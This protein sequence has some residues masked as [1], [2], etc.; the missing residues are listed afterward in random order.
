[1]ANNRSIDYVSRDFDSIVDALISFAT[2][3]F[4]PDTVANRQWT[5]FNADDFSRTWLELVAYVGDLIF[6]YLDV[7]ATQSNIETATIRKNILD[8]AKQFGFVVSTASSSSEVATFML[9]TPGTVPIGFRVSSENGQEFFTSSSSPAPGSTTLEVILPV[10]QGAQRQESFIARG[11]QNEE[12]TLGVTGLV[13]DTTN[14]ISSLISPGVTVNGDT[15]ELVDTFI[16]SLPTDKHFRVLIDS[17]GRAILRFGD[18]VFGK[19]LS[20]ND[21]IVT[22]YRTGGGSAG[23]IPANT[24]TTLLDQSTFINAVTNESAFSGGADE[25]SITQL[26]ELVPASLRTLERAVTVQDYADIILTNF[27]NVSKASA[28]QNLSDAGIDIDIFVVPAGNSITKITDNLPLFNAVSDFIDERKPVTTTFKIKDAFG[29]DIF[30][31][32]TIFLSSG[33]SRSLVESNITTSLLNFFNFSSGDVDESGTKFAQVIRLI[34]LY[35]VVGTVEGIERFEITKLHYDPRVE[36]SAAIGANYLFSEIELFP[37]SNS[38]EW[39]IGPNENAD[40]PNFNSFTVFKKISGRVSNLSE[41]SLT[42]D[43][44]NFSVVESTTTGVNTDGSSNIV[45]D[46]SKTF[47]IDEFVG[48]SSSITLSNLSGNTFDHTVP[49]FIPKIGDRIIQGANTARIVSIVDSDTFVVSNGYPNAL[50]N[51]AAFLKRDTH[52]LVDAAGNVWSIDDNDSHSILLSAFAVNNTIVSDVASGEYKIVKSLIGQNLI[53]HSLIFAGI[54][55]NT[56]NSIFRVN[57]AFNLVGTIGDEFQ[58]S[59]PQDNIGNFG[60]PLTLD[61][62]ISNTPS[63]GFGAVHC[64]GNPDLSSITGGPSSRYT[65][66]DSNLRTFEIISVNNLSKTVVILHDATQTPAPAVGLPLGPTSSGKPA[67]IAPRYYSDNNE[68]SFVVGLANR[69]GGLGFQAIGAIAINTSITG[70]DI[71][72][73]KQFT[74]NDGT[75]PAVTFEFDKVGGVAFGNIAIPYTNGD[76]AAAIK[77]AI[78]GAINGAPLLA[79]SASDGT[80]LFGSDEVVFLQNDNIGSIGNQSIIDTVNISGITFAGMSGGIGQGHSVPTPVIPGPGDSVNDLG[81][82]SDGTIVDHFEFRTSGFVDDI[83]NLRNSEIPEMVENDIELD[84]RGGVT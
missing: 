56:H 73:G 4:G 77:S 49:T 43:S 16:R 2:V 34:D 51:G 62:F 37:N 35:N 27:N 41:G 44:I 66:I 9:S 74:L 22:N 26:R 10:I 70:S 19:Q 81:I 78:I 84:F 61:Q 12:I 6:Y 54:E 23:N 83:V 39:L 59:D 17:E 72:D 58:L 48:G 32:A 46:I 3:N 63:I 29:M 33:A 65:L 28:A 31:K 45:F 82:S 18:G 38:A 5:D 64:A 68:V 57:S 36:Q 80:G 52:L 1:M 11:V 42:D 13:I 53:F 50:V 8:I 7:Q 75:N 60:I 24:L 21:S 20:P 71:A 15:Y 69:A 55:Y 47:L 76:N 79:I 25:P 40:S 14:P 30:F 67:S